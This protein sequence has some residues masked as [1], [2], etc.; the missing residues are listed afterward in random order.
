LRETNDAAARIYPAGLWLAGRVTVVVGGGTIAQRRVAGLRAASADVTVIA[1]E[2]TTALEAM[3]EASELRW[4]RRGY[5]EGDLAE[6]W[7][8]VAATDDAAVNAAVAG[9]A[10]RRR[11][12]CSRAD[13]ARDS[14][15]WT[16]AV[17]RRG[18]LTIAVL[19]DG[20]DE[21][22]IR[23]EVANS[24][25]RVA[26]DTARRQGARRGD[27]RRSAALRDAVLS[28]LD[29]GT[30]AMPSR[31][32][33]GGSVA[34]VGGGPG[35]ADLITVRG[36]AL[37]AAAD[38]VIVDR[39]APRELLAQLAPDVEVVDAAKV[40][41]GRAMA[42]DEINKLLVSHARA[43][44]FVVRLKG[45]DPFVFGRGMEEVAFCAEAGVP[46]TVV[47]GVTSAIA[48]PAIAGV[49][50]THRGVS[51]EF[52]VVS[53]HV[54]PGSPDSLIDWAALARLRG[55][56]VL[57][58]SLA[59]LDEIADALVEHGKPASTPA[60][61]VQEGSLPNERRLFTTLGRLAADTKA[62]TIHPPA[63]VVIGDVV[64]LGHA[65][66]SARDSLDP[67]TEAATRPHA[68]P[69]MAGE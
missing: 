21:A 31:R 6:A 62:A 44:R 50:V 26:A 27:P 13:D 43:G 42:Q 11:V 36:R 52:T 34:L 54:P 57:L 7:Y 46:C 20:V 40:P 4:L 15:A 12:F 32:A 29:D 53:G 10:E 1:P 16:P 47:P 14:S 48:V 51:H 2:L 61:V 59:W 37:L 68:G 22:S 5:R 69:G 65:D 3:A 33:P 55:T 56:L 39:L 45:G 64:A 66:R 17:G 9:E 24:P 49:P 41:R 25:A 35:D 38:V 8:V 63:I 18:A 28:G 58:M 30:L 60:V 19:C 23:E 67:V